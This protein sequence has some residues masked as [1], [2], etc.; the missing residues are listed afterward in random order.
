M[1]GFPLCPACRSEYQDPGNRRFHAEP[2]GCP[3][4]GPVLEFVQGDETIA[5]NDAALQACVAAIA[6]GRIVAIKGIGG[7]H[8]MCD[9][10]SD[11]AIDRLRA[12][13]Q[14]PHKP[15]AVMF[16]APYCKPLA[17]V[18]RSVCLS[19]DQMDLLLTPQRPIVLVNKQPHNQLSDLVAP[20]LEEIGVMLPYSPLHHLLLNDLG[21][22]LVATSANISGEPVLT[23]N[24][25]VTSRLGH[26]VDACLHHNRPIARP[27]DDPVYRIIHDRPRPLRHGRGSAPLELTLATPLDRPVIATG[28]HMKNTVALAWDN[29]VVISP[30]I[31]DLENTRSRAVFEQ[32]L[33]DLQSLYQVTATTV[34]CDA[35]PGYASTHWAEHCGLPVH[36]VFHHHAHAATAFDCSK[37]NRPQLVFT[38]DG[39]GYGEDGTLW[40]GEALLG[41]PGN[42]QRVA[43]LR[44]FFLPGGER[45]GREPWRSA[46]ALCWQAGLDWPAQPANGALLHQAWQRRLNSPQSSAAGRLFDAAAA[47][48]G[49]CTEASYEGQGPMLLEA[50]AD[51][52][53][54]AISLPLTTDDS[55]LLISD[56]APLLPVLLDSSRDI[57]AR[58]GCLHA[59]LADTLLLQ[60]QTIRKT[61]GVSHV[62]L[63]G[64]VFQ[65]RLLTGQAISLL[66]GDGFSVYMADKIPANDAGISYGQ[67]LEFA[68]SGSR[69]PVAAD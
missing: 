33:N 26:V 29:R 14:R 39:T 65:N 24:I 21:I 27:A 53:A 17:L 6:A 16:P 3:E 20:G 52:N 59:S 56:W 28:G 49:L 7:Y 64:G 32:T 61:H 66:G 1:S 54:D 43:S 45:A 69:R 13:K 25:S 58:A 2:V 68:F 60:A 11:S 8:I 23:D 15:L 55:G 57:A 31:G 34:I 18:T 48:T 46:A 35:H 10:R 9:A 47:L 50:I 67:V 22:P 51:G 19:R 62:G 12:R 63:S 36:R 5:G 42:W 41:T 4:C 40:G 37:T 38:W 30:H 44:P